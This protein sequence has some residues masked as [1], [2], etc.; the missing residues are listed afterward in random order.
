[1]RPICWLHVSDIHLTMSDDWAQDVALRAMCE[2][3]SHQRGHETAPDFILMTGD[4]AF[5]GKNEEYARASRFFDALSD[6]SGVPRN[7]I[8]CIPGNHDVDR[9]RQSL[10]F[11]G[12]RT[13]LKTQNHVDA[14]LAPT[15]ELATLLQRLEAFR[16]FQKAYFLDQDRLWTSDGLGYVSHLTIDEIRLAIVGLNSAWLAGGGKGDHG[17]LLIGEHQVIEA[18]RLLNAADDAPHVV[19]GMTHHPLH[20]LQ[21]FDRVPALNRLESACQFLHCGHLHTPEARAAGLSGSGCLT[22]TSGASFETRHSNNSYSVVQ[23][24]LHAATRIVTN[25]RFNPATGTFSNAEPTSYV[26]EIAPSGRCSVAELA[27][28][29]ASFHAA[30]APWANYLAAVLLERKTELPILTNDGSAF[31]AFAVVAETENR[32]RDATI[33]FMAFRNVLRVLYGRADLVDILRRYGEAVAR[34]G[35]ALDDASRDDGELQA[36]LGQLEADALALRGAESQP[37]ASH[38]EALLLDLAR[39]GDWIELRA[40]SERHVDSADRTIAMQ[41][42]RML[43]LALAKTGE[44]TDRVA[45][46]GLYRE[47]LECG[48]AEFTDAGILATLLHEEGLP[49]EA[50]VVLLVAIERF[51]VDKSDYFAGIGQDIV[52]AG[53]DRAFRKQLEA[54]IAQGRQRA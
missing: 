52:G 28:A 20:V 25:V 35:V 24:D 18:I 30:L 23:L 17:K 45:A 21:E 5:S 14:L 26:M 22:L 50:K 48:N 15:E 12:A 3:I 27:N 42:K 4:V 46:I 32:L 41:A 6:A 33:A 47:L 1:M 8:F 40:H 51:S 54:A 43:A 7:L 19:L 13:V 49:D 16:Q 11:V 34:Y 2:H 37:G 39:S 38:T 53:G 9:D 44:R 36:R 10:C 29:L 31:G